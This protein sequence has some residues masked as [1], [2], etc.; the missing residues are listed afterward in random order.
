[1]IPLETPIRSPIVDT[2]NPSL[3]A[4]LSPGGELR[5]AGELQ[6]L[7]DE[8]DA[9]N[10]DADHKDDGAEEL[11]E[12]APRFRLVRGQELPVFRCAQE[13]QEGRDC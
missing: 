3:S 10:A 5:L 12:V 7:D 8:A 4:K 2:P 11:K 1:M 9:D 13:R 6:Q